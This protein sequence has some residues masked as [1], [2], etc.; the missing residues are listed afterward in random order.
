MRKMPMTVAD[1]EVVEGSEGGGN[2]EKNFSFFLWN[3][4]EMKEWREPTL[5]NGA[6][7][8]T[9]EVIKQQEN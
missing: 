7:K 4:F 9:T 2:E 3:N 6:Q 1:A 5:H 8:E